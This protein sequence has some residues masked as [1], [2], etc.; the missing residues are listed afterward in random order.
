MAEYRLVKISAA[1]NTETPKLHLLDEL[2]AEQFSKFVESGK[3]IEELTQTRRLLKFVEQN[4]E[5]INNFLEATVRSLTE[6]SKL[7]NSVGKKELD[8]LYLNVNRLLLNY[9]SSMRTFLDHSRAYLSRKYGK[10]STELTEFEQMLSA[11]FDN[12]FTY[13]FFDKLRNYAQHV[14]IPV[15]FYSFHT[16]YDDKK[17]TVSG[18]LEIQF[19]RKKLLESYDGWG[20]HVLEHLRNMGENFDVMPM[21]FEMTQMITEIERNLELIEK[22]HVVEAVK[23]IR[24]L[25]RNLPEEGWD[26]GISENIEVE[27]NGKLKNISLL[28]VPVEMIQFIEDRWNLIVST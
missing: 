3:C 2:S 9:L 18:T 26:V 1:T 15:H 13:R 20:K 7:K 21:V 6:K 10:V 22:D 28:I 27:E 14:G 4:E 17:Q 11:F 23:Y 25:I 12:S 8:P 19:N 5:D 16:H 24:S